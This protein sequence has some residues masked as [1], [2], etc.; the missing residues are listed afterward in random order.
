MI[1]KTIMR[2]ITVLM[3]AA[4]FCGCPSD[5]GTD[6]GTTG[7]NNTNNNGN[8]IASLQTVIS[9]AAAGSSIDLSLY[10]ITDYDAVIDKAVEIT[11]G[12]L[13]SGNITIT[14]GG[15]E[16]SGVSGT[17][18]V[19][20]N[21]SLKISGS[22]LS[23]LSIANVTSSSANRILSRAANVVTVEIAN[24]TVGAVI[25]NI[26]DSVL[27]VSGSET[28]IT[29]IEVKVSVS[30]VLQNVTENNITFPKAD[31]MP[32]GVTLTLKVN[33]NETTEIIGNKTESSDSSS[34]SDNGDDNSSSS[35][36]GDSSSSSDSDDSSSS[37]SVSD[38]SSS[39]EDDSSSASSSDSGDS[40]S[41][42]S[43]SE[44]ANDNLSGNISFGDDP[45]L[46]LVMRNEHTGNKDGDSWTFDLTSDLGVD[47]S[48]A[49]C[50]WTSKLS[51]G[52][53]ELV[54]YGGIDNQYK[55]ISPEYKIGSSYS[56]TAT[57]LQEGRYQLYIE[58][59]VLLNQGTANN[60]SYYT[61]ATFDIE[62]VE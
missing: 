27:N 18:K 53:H 59:K 39:S 5:N 57:L 58:V 4:T 62:I 29:S 60:A 42:S 22:S 25:M 23:S 51:K 47:L 43:S 31:D 2:L 28:K 15:V 35:S 44:S 46:C 40:S 24:S 61:S 49:D 12:S 38:S 13:G 52:S 26:E 36:D 14:S 20:T 1:H 54:G 17:A 34:S 33:E 45:M 41:S 3:V 30:I 48:G 7:N 10:E 50:S 9:D 55:D 16:L 37:G 19:T 56:T 8:K 6:S 21:S 11:N 32:Q